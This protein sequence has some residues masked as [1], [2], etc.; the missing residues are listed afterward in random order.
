[1][2]LVSGRPLSRNK[3]I[4]SSL[5]STTMNSE[6]ANLRVSKAISY[7]YAFKKEINPWPEVVASVAS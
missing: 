1:M 4:I 3:W 5:H 2:K 6:Y 7:G